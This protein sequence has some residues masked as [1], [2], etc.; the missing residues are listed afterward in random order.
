MLGALALM[1]TLLLLAVPPTAVKA[2]CTSNHPSVGFT[3]S[4]TQYAHQ[5]KGDFEIVDDCTF[6]VTNFRYDG[7]GPAV[8]WTSAPSESDLLAR[9]N[10][11]RIEKNAQEIPAGNGFTT[12]TVTIKDSLTWD[13][14]PVVS[15]FCEPFKANFGHI[16]PSFSNCITLQE[17]KL[18]LLW[19]VD[20]DTITFA[21]EGAISDTEWMAF[22]I[23]EPTD[24]V[25]MPGSDVTVV[26]FVGGE[27]FVEDY[28]LTGRFQ[29]DYAGGGSAGVCPD[30]LLGDSSDNNVNLV[31]AQR[32]NGV[33]FVAWSRQIDTGDTDYDHVFSMSERAY[34]FA[35]GPLGEA[36]TAELPIVLYH[37]ATQ[38][39]P[40][41]FTI[42]LSQSQQTCALLQADMGSG[43]SSGGGSCGVTTIG[44]ET[45]F[46]VTTGT[47]LNYPNPPA[48][49]ISYWINGMESPLLRVFRGVEYT[50]TIKAT[51]QHPLYITNDIIGGRANADMETVYAGSADAWGTGD[52][53]Y[54][55]KWTPD[56]NTPDTV[57]YQC[58]IH[59]K[60]G[61]RISVEGTDERPM[62]GGDDDNGDDDDEMATSACPRTHD[63]V[64]RTAEFSELQHRWRGRVTVIDDCSFMVEE[65]RYDG[66]APAVYW[67]GSTGKSQS[68]LRRGFRLN[69]QRVQGAPNGGVTRVIT[70]DGVTWD[71]VNVI[72]GWCEAFNALFGLVDLRSAEDTDPDTSTGDNCDPS[73]RDDATCMA[74]LSTDFTLHWKVVAEDV[75]F[76][77][78]FRNSAGWVGLAIPEVPEFM[79][80][81]DAVI[82]SDTMIPNAYTLRERNR[83]GIV[84]APDRIYNASF[85][86]DGT[87]AILAFSRP[88]NNSYSV[89]DLSSDVNF[90]W[91]RGEDDTLAYHGAD[92]G[93]F[94]VNLA[95]GS[96]SS[97]G[98]DSLTNDRYV[99]GVL[100]GLGWA[101]FLP[102]GPIFAR[103]TKICPEEKRHVWFHAHVMCQAVGMLLATVGFFFALS[104]F[105]DSGRGSTYHHRTL[106]IVVMILAYWQLVNAAVRPK[107]NGGTTRT[108][109]ETVHWLSG[110]VA[111]AL[112]VINVL[113]GIEVLHEV[114]GDNRRVW[115]VGFATTFVIVT[116]VAD[117]FARRV[118]HKQN[119]ER[120]TS[121]SQAP[122]SEEPVHLGQFDN[123]PY[124]AKVSNI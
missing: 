23:P 56:D 114:T 87:T 81:A 10:T 63:F 112:G 39:A 67:W 74:Q 104:K 95:S 124:N 37:G 1:A 36:S 55:L 25:L 82:A 103:I 89:V 71:D 48:W 76:V 30:R 84:P 86:R 45:E 78:E 72:A 43:S 7:N 64:G 17:D 101:V 49:G 38:H 44:D 53:P 109:W 108:V 69:S 118:L 28:Y 12:L 33:S 110:R 34:V 77:G 15:G 31:Y 51:S 3:G 96:Q 57:Y 105:S 92:R 70:L 6:R 62:V 119:A 121:I 4:F 115:F 52:S 85:T 13:D 94:A 59:Q 73:P 2:A 14:I 54:V 26:G 116:I 11:F 117:G 42:N 20:G 35:Y 18:N 32:E 61:W 68:D 40:D 91:A 120:K 22:G 111:V 93:F 65:F 80:G 8:Y 98:A 16:A 75:S 107:P 100:M 60:L 123:E 46:V 113:V 66:L 41:G 97:G 58:W 102:A 27:P 5:W 29:C 99:H 83:A 50:F 122:F 9:Q 47:N 79:L 106:G 90:I 24:R 88:I 21:L 19:D